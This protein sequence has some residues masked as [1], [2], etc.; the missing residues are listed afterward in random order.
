MWCNSWYRR[1]GLARVLQREFMPALGKPRAAVYTFQTMEPLQVCPQKAASLR[2]VA[3]PGWRVLGRAE[4]RWRAS[5]EC[6]RVARHCGAMAEARRRSSVA[7]VTT[8]AAPRAPRGVAAA[9]VEQLRALAVALAL[10]AAVAPVG[11]MIEPLVALGYLLL[12]GVVPV[13][14][15]GALP[16]DRGGVSMVVGACIGAWFG[17]GGVAFAAM[18]ANPRA[19]RFIPHVVLVPAAAGMLYCLWYSASQAASN[20]LEL[21][22]YGVLG[23]YICLLAPFISFFLLLLATVRR[24]NGKRAAK[25]IVLA[26]LVCALTA[27]IGLLTCLYVVLSYRVTGIAGLAVNG[28]SARAGGW[29]GV[30]RECAAL[31]D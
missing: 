20:A 11:L 6:E 22:G 14:P 3:W 7:V 16:M 9:V 8:R 31:F 2:S 13:Q 10:A 21:S 5:G 12:P 25:G 4:G 19:A 24:K 15:C 17:Q 28:E 23:N 18:E 30:C 1:L 29:G 26:S 27:C